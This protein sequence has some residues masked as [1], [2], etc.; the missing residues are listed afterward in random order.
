MILQI[1]AMM[2]VDLLF[3]LL[4]LILGQRIYFAFVL[5]GYLYFLAFK[6]CI[7]IHPLTHIHQMTIKLPYPLY[8]HA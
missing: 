2:L 3:V 1:L 8:H 5:T 6:K 7:C 4:S